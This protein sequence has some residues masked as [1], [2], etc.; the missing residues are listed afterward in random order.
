MKI[1]YEDYR[2]NIVEN[3]N[4]NYDIYD[5][6]YGGRAVHKN[7]SKEWTDN[8]IQRVLSKRKKGRMR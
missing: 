5:S 7:K 4:A 3:S 2:L 6:K 8:F 1:Y